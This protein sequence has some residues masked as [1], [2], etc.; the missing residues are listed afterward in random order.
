[1]FKKIMIANRGEIALRLLRSFRELGI[2]T[3]VAHSTADQESKPVILSDQSIC[4]GAPQP[5]NS[6]LNIPNLLSA[7]FIADVDAIHPGIGFLS[8]NSSFAKKTK[9]LGI[10]FIG[11]SPQHL[12]MMGDKITAKTAAI[13][14][15]LPIIPGSD[16]SV[17][18]LTEAKK[19]AQKIGYPIILKAASGGGGRGMKVCMNETDLDKN[20]DI[21][22]QEAEAAFADNRV[23]LEK[24]LQKPR[25]IEVQVLG[26][27][28]GRGW[29]F[30]ERDC[31]IQRRHQKVIEEAPSPALNNDLRES[32]CHRAKK[33]V[34]EMG[35]LGPGTFEFLYENNEFYFIE[36]NTRLQVEHT[37]SE[38]ITGYN[39]VE[40][41]LK[42]CA[43]DKINLEQKDIHIHGHAIE[44]RINA[45]SP[46]TFQPHPGEITRWHPPGGLGVRVDS[47]AYTGYRIPAYYDSLVAKLITHGNNR[48]Q[49][50]QRTIQALTEFSIEGIETIIPLHLR[51]LATPEFQSSDYTIHWLE[52]FLN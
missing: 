48:Q 35:Y 16:G 44:C 19:L 46:E 29:H 4:I 34:E 49:T 43:G 32:I 30:Y 15:G 31:S 18:N 39:L 9:E 14:Y 37:I 52:E 5:K 40:L 33:A 17:E 42:T 25:H 36:M 26:D 8:E 21:C 10:T 11:P 2:E 51:I 28:Q 23:Y 47:H 6:Y 13:N 12:D 27:G 45:E 41:Q 38:M 7:A 50:I 3:V 20:Y 24:Y 1:M 22:R